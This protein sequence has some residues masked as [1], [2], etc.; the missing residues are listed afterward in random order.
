MVRMEGARTG[1]VLWATYIGFNT[2]I[3]PMVN[4]L[5]VSLY[6]FPVIMTFAR[7][8]LHLSLVSAALV[9]FLFSSQCVLRQRLGR[10][11]VL[12]RWRFM[13]LMHLCIVAF[14]HS[15]W[16]HRYCQNSWR[17]VFQEYRPSLP[18]ATNRIVAA[19]RHY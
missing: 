17:C 6:R 14:L 4:R 1:A 15:Y 10:P 18:G 11:Y 16:W 5:V 19:P 13:V 12:G 2:I 8:V 3:F 9:V 7:C